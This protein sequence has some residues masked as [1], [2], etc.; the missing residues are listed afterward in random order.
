MM[1]PIAIRDAIV[2]SFEVQ[3]HSTAGDSLRRVIDNLGPTHQRILI[4]EIRKLIRSTANNAAQGLAT[5]EE[6]P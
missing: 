6:T 5:D 2:E 3:L 4:D 1:G